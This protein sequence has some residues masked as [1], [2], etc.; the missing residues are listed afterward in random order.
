[1]AIDN[2]FN[3]LWYDNNLFP[4]EPEPLHR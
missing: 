1:M 3:N 4:T 2:S